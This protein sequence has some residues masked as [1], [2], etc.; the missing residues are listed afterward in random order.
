MSVFWELVGYALLAVFAENLV[1]TGGIGSSRMLR[2]ALQH[3]SLFLY[4]VYLPADQLL[5]ADP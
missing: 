2:A 3:F 4:P 1:L 5:R